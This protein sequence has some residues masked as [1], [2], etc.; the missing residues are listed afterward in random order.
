[1][2][3]ELDWVAVPPLGSRI[4]VEDLE[5]DDEDWAALGEELK[6]E[7]ELATEPTA[8]ALPIG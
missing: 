7:L 1:M 6:F 8:F 5:L 4:I 3:V 2:I